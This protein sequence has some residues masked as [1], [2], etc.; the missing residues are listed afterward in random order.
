MKVLVAMS[1]GVDSAVAAA[2]LRNQGHEVAAVTMRIWRDGR[3][4]GGSRDACFG[5]GEEVDIAAAQRVCDHLGIP[6]RVLDCS[7][8]YERIVLED[9]RRGYGSGRTPNPC[10][11]CNAAVKF[12]V[13]PRLAREAGLSY[14][15]FA[16][17]H[18]VRTDH[19]DGRHRLLTARDAAK[20]QSYFL[21]RLG[22]DQVAES[23]FPLGDLT[24]DA[25]RHLA[26]EFSL[27]VRDKP[28]SQDF[29]A[30]DHR[31]LLGFPA[32]TGA[33][34]DRSG[35]ILGR[36]DG[37]W[38]YTIGQ[39]R[40]L[41]LAAGRPL[42]VV[43]IVPETNTVVVG[44]RQETV[45]HWLT[46]GDMNWVSTARPEEA[47]D[48]RVKVRSA[49]RAVP[50]RVQPL[51]DGG[52]RVDFPDGI[53]AVPPGQSAVLYRDDALLAGGIIE[54]TGSHSLAPAVDGRS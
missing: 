40:G 38:N 43:D 37:C 4:L 12:G 17:G 7:D 27:A 2:L 23:L 1:G 24:K 21:Y 3:Y 48:A 34:T 20:D 19:R 47:F 54:R 44:D 29:Y 8:D 42:Y 11:R 33:F 41:G 5:P 10:V 35:R 6:H 32:A 52:C 30:G 13:L 46:A 53:A 49:G 39:R 50:C 16:T 25:V 22:Q 45:R 18:Y 51:A 14:D 15:R 31:E 26:G 28:D 9:F 36:H